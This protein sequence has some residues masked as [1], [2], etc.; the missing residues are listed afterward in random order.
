MNPNNSRPRTSDPPSLVAILIAARLAGDRQ[1]EAAARRELEAQ[2][3]M[4]VRFRRKR[5]EA[6]HA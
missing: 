2:H 1:M 6:A 3:Q 5:R 4:T